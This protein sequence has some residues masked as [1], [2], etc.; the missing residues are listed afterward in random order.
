MTPGDAAPAVAA[1][2]TRSAASGTTKRP[3]KDAFVWSDALLLEEQLS[4][5]ER[6]VRDTARSY[7]QDKLMSR[8]QHGFRHEHFDREIMTEMGELGL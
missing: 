4:E 5:D 8:V 2:P 3:A 1:K 6:L 7:A